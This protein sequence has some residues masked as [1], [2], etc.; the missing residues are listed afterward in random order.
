ME[1]L[2]KVL[3]KLD[4]VAVITVLVAILFFICFAIGWTI[5][6]RKNISNCLDS[7]FQQKTE[8]NKIKAM[9][10]EDHQKLEEYRKIRVD[11]QEQADKIHQ[12]LADAIN[13]ITE[14]LDN[15]QRNFIEDKIENMRWKI[16]EFGNMLMNGKTCHKEQFDNI[17]K[18]YD[19]YE[20]I[21][22]ENGMSN[23]QVEETMKF[24]R[25][26]YQELMNGQLKD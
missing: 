20:R 3:T 2:I 16:L 17:F 26:K 19:E 8:K 10:Y 11:D 22:A 5:K 24:I 23:G 7:W 15:I 21:L 6:H 13:A 14:K 25:E 4:A 9:I 12:Q 1:D 18:I